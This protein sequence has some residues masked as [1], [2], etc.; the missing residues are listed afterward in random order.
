MNVAKAGRTVPVTYRVTLPDGTPVADPAHFVQL[1]SQA[2]TPCG[3]AP[4]DQVETSAGRSG[5]QYLGDGTWQFNWKTP[6]SYAGQC[7]TMILT[8]AD[9]SVHTARFSFR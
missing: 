2:G 4:A 3:G 9:G 7:R 6:K 5:L 1:T 8:L